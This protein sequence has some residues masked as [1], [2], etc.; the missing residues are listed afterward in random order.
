MIRKL[1]EEEP[2]DWSFRFTSNLSL[3]YPEVCWTML[4][5]IW[6]QVA[7]KTIAQSDCLKMDKRSSDYSRESSK[8]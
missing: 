2:I 4:D 6:S 8:V 7:L 3:Y 5:D 1:F